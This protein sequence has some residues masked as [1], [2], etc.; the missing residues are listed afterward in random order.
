MAKVNNNQSKPLYQICDID[1]FLKTVDEGVDEFMS[2]DE[3]VRT[4]EPL[5]EEF[6][7]TPK[8][9]LEPLESP[10]LVKEGDITRMLQNMEGILPACERFPRSYVP[11]QPPNQP[12]IIMNDRIP[13]LLHEKFFKF[14]ADPVEETSDVSNS[15]DGS[16]SGYNGKNN[17]NDLGQ[18]EADYRRKFW[19]VFSDTDFDCID[20]SGS[21]EDNNTVRVE[22]MQRCSIAETEQKASNKETVRKYY[23]PYEIYMMKRGNKQQL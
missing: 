1:E 17:G 14:P 9:F 16:S 12:D 15:T 23:T 2:H 3:Y 21:D 20:F 7:K 4:R 13:I 11:P 10:G 8:E 18:T 22:E 19:T 6:I 5:P